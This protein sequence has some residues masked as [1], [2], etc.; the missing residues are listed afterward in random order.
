MG[1]RRL[2]GARDEHLADR[3][4]A[5]LLR[6]LEPTPECSHR[7]GSLSRVL[8]QPELDDI[9]D[10]RRNT[11]RAEVGRS[12]ERDSPQQGRDRV[13]VGQPER[14]RAGEQLVHRRGQR[15][16]VARG[17]RRLPSQQLGRR[18]HERRGDLARRGLVGALHV[19]NAEVAEVRFTPGGQQDVLGLHVPMEHSLAARAL[20]RTGELHPV[21]EHVDPRNPALDEKVVELIRQAGTP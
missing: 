13:F 21:V 3:L 6:L 9:S 15:I 16:E 17:P 11:T 18:V 10:G 7:L 12:V 2:D 4:A 14:W 19:G 8:R 5:R 1:D 20:E